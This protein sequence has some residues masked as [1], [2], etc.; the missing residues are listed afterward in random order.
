MITSKTPLAATKGARAGDFARF[1]DG[2]RRFLA[3]LPVLTA[4]KRES[5]RFRRGFFEKSEKR[6][7]KSEIK[8]RVE[9]RRLT[10][11]EKFE[12]RN[13]AVKIKTRTLARPT[14]GERGAEKK[15]RTSVLSRF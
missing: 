15:R 9:R 3:F 4:T 6:V 5:F 14:A 10:P 8:N 1:P 7:G 12:K 11:F 13:D 2:E